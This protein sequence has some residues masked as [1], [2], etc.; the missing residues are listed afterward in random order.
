[1]RGSQTYGLVK[2][3]GARFGVIAILLFLSQTSTRLF[4]QECD[5][6][7]SLF[8]E[9]PNGVDAIVATVQRGRPFLRYLASIDSQGRVLFLRDPNHPEQTRVAML[10]SRLFYR[11]V[12]QA[13]NAVEVD[14]TQSQRQSEITT[15][16]GLLDAA[17][18]GALGCQAHQDGVDR[19]I[20]LYVAGEETHFEC[21][22]NELGR[23]N[24]YLVD[25]VI[26]AVTESEELLCQ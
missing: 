3:R 26:N 1:M 7:D 13:Y 16:E 5:S 11:L 8:G 12:A 6:V 20:T 17:E 9:P 23:F 4:A 15:L 25:V 21:V 24:Q 22:G 14:R 18:Q 10:T 2:K 19:N